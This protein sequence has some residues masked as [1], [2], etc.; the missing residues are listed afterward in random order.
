MTDDHPNSDEAVSPGEP[1]HNEGAL[2]RLETRLARSE[3]QIATLQE[4]MAEM[5]TFV[6]RSRQRA[7]YLR[8]GILVA[9]LGAFFYLQSLK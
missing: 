5:N 4:G 3:A 7:L 9:L 8:I 6:R 2:S 1:E